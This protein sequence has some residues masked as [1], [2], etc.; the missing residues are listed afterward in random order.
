MPLGH[1]D[2]FRKEKMAEKLMTEKNHRDFWAEVKKFEGRTK[3]IAP[4]VDE[5]TSPEEITYVFTNKYKT[6]YNSVPSEKLLMDD[7]K[8]QIKENLMVYNDNTHTVTVHEMKNAIHKLRG[9]KADGNAGLWSNH[10]IYAPEQFVVHLS[11]LAS[12]MIS[13]GYNP[14]D[15]LV[16]TIISLPKDSM[17]DISDSENYR[18]ICLCSCITKL[19]DWCMLN[20]YS[21]QFSTSGFH[22]NQTTQHLC[23]V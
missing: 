5:A 17:G 13:H 18:G 14:Q 6:L 8:N 2:D 1:G 9:E 12:A 4:H 11:I 23:V 22:S 21:K 20:R 16:G 10:V 19:L 15:L 7:I 3:C